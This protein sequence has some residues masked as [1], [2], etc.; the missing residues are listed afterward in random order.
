MKAEESIL[1]NPTKLY[2]LLL[3][4]ESDMHGYEIIAEFGKRL[5]KKLS[6]GQIYPL[7]RK[8]MK[9]GFI[10]VYEEFQGKRKRKVYTLTKEGKDYCEEVVGKLKEMFDILK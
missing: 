5:G 4:N 3:L 8:M 6:P 7:L 9:K 2:V 10:N 1:T